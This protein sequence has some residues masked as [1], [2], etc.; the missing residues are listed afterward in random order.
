MINYLNNSK[1]NIKLYIFIIFEHYSLP[2]LKVFSLSVLVFCYFLIKNRKS[3]DKIEN[4]L[5]NLIQLLFM[6]I[7]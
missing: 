4:S 2:K 1:K 7:Y 5:L 3:L 6:E